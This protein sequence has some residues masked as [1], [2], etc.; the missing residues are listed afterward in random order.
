M[1]LT[2]ITVVEIM[3]SSNGD[4]NRSMEKSCIS[5]NNSENAGD[6]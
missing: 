1:S 3:A 4:I 6:E 5:M 2:K